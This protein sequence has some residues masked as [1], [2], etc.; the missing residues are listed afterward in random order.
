MQCRMLWMST[1]IQHRFIR[2]LA[3]KNTYQD[4]ALGVVLAKMIAKSTLPTMNRLH[5]N[6]LSVSI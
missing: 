4:L 2:L 3:R 1:V 5:N 6:L